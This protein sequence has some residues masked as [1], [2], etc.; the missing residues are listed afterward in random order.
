ML[1]QEVQFPP[2]DPFDKED[3][4]WVEKTN[5]YGSVKKEVLQAII[6][7]NKLEHFVDMPRLPLD[8]SSE[9]EGNGESRSSK[10]DNDVV[11]H[12]THTVRTFPGP[13]L[14]QC[15]SDL[16]LLSITDRIGGGCQIG[17]YASMVRMTAPRPSCRRWS[18]Y[19]PEPSSTLWQ[20][21]VRGRTRH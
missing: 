13:T 7:W 10:Q 2:T 21:D 12:S 17:F 6:P 3:I 16:V 4:N 19:L 14:R 5:H 8:L 9:E 11:L 18:C 20:L 1:R 15:I